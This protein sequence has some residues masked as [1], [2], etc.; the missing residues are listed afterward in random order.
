MWRT[1]HC[2]FWIVLKC[3]GLTLLCLVGEVLSGFG[4]VSGAGVEMCDVERYI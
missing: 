2:F 4:M 1:L 3:I